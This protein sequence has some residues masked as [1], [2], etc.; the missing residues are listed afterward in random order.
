[1]STAKAPAA[2]SGRICEKLRMFSKTFKGNLHFEIHP[3]SFACET[4]KL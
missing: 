1:M 2:P 3:V 4:E